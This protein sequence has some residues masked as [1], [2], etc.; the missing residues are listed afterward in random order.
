[1]IYNKHDDRNNQSGC[2]D[3]GNGKNYN[4]ALNEAYTRIYQNIDNTYTQNAE[5]A[6]DRIYWDTPPS[7]F[8]M[9][10]QARKLLLEVIPK[11][12]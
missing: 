9:F 12:N 3:V 8:V 6:S 2:Y 7:D 10:T 4:E 5:I 11:S 1:M